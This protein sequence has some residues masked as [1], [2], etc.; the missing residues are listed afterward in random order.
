M[1]TVVELTQSQADAKQL[2]D[3]TVAQKQSEGFALL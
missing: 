2:Y 3:Q 1:T